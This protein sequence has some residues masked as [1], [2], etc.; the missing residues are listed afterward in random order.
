MR[1]GILVATIGLGL[2]LAWAIHRPAA[3]P[4]SPPGAVGTSTEDGT[5]IPVH[6]HPTG[7]AGVA[8]LT[9][10]AAG[11]R[12]ALTSGA[13]PLHASTPVTFRI[14]GPDGAPVTRFDVVN[15]RPM[16]AFLVRTDLSTFEHLH[17]QL[18]ADGV[19]T[20]TLRADQPGPYRFYVDFTPTVTG[21]PTEITLSTQLT[22]AGAYRAESLPAPARQATAGPF[23]VTLQ[24][25][26]YAGQSSPLDFV[27]L[28]GGAP[29]GSQLQPYLG[30]YGHLVALRQRD[31]GFVHVH[32]ETELDGG[33]IEFWITPPDRG[34]YRL[35]LNFQVGTAV[36]TASFVVDVT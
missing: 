33:A 32:A 17:P 28:R 13:L 1:W 5:G 20:V 8:G 16:H 23:T 4:D 25:T 26:P 22:V 15:D 10:T 3:G 18:A 7:P 24:G 29:V 11:Y 35:F 30:S 14:L 34:R 31:L 27:V 9:E 6:V 12:L 19:W 2:G 21:T 36:E